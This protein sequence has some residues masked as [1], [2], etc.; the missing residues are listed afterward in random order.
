MI[1]SLSS[2]SYNLSLLDKLNHKVNTALSTQEA[3]EYGSDDSVL[4]SK[5]LGIRGDINS[6][7]S[8]SQHID[9]SKAFNTTSDDTMAQVKNITQSTIAEL[10]E[11]NTDTTGQNQREI[12]ATQLEDFRES[13]LALSNTEVDGQYLFSGVNTNV[14]S[15]TKDP[16]TGVIS[17]QSDNST[18]KI[19]VED[20]TYT[21]Q[22][23]NGIEAF[24]YV[25]TEVSSGQKFGQGDTFTFDSTETVM[26]DDGNVWQLVDT[27]GDTSFDGLYINGDTS[28][29]PI[30]VTD[31]G[32]GT[33]TM[34]N[35][36]S[37]VVLNISSD[38]DSFT[39]TSNNIILDKEGNEWE[40]T[41]I[42]NDGT[43]DNLFINGD[44][45][46][47]PISVVD[48]GDGTFTASNTSVAELEVH[49][50]VFDD[51]DTVIT[52]LRL[53]DKDD[54]T[55]T[56]GDQKD[57]ISDV[58][59]RMNRA[60]ESQNISHSLVGTRTST[61]ESYGSI[62]STK[63]TNLKILEKEYATADLTELGIQAKALEITY[64]ALYSTISRV[65]E[66]SLVNYMR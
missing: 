27:N 30:P 9:L 36:T 15:F 41:D 59:D 28:T 8:I 34:T 13:L 43:F 1:K 42:N 31:N 22:G 25:D 45:T 65:N 56:V 33:V 40:L 55:I 39:F 60:F 19:N 61:I 4:Y 47:T 14:M 46:T 63:L 35:N 6:Y 64:T 7:D 18:K 17:Y 5:I 26:D 37:N 44:T 16:N 48:N 3:L 20:A 53:K 62:V 49:R 21:A 23:I 12:I 57:V 11:A 29:T 50:S 2:I 32:D 54:N 24:Y 51:L 38:G 10:I 52:A 66:L 58:L